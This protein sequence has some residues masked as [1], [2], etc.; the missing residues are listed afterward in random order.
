MNAATKKGGL[1]RGLD[2]LFVDN[3]TDS[4]AEQPADLYI[5]E[6]EPDRDQPRQDFDQEALSEL[7]ESIAQH[8]VI[9]PIIV[10]PLPGG[11]YRIVAGERRW[12]A[13]RLAGK[14]TIPAVVH[15]LTDLEAMTYALIENLQREDLNPVEEAEGYRRLVE[16][17]GL[18]QE[19]VAKLVGRSRSAVANAL[20]LLTLPEE[21]LKLLRDGQLTTGHAKAVLAV[22]DAARRGE[23]ARMVAEKGLTVREAERLSQKTVQQQ[24]ISLP[25]S[26]DPVIAEVELSLR[27]ALGV[28]VRVTC[29]NERGTLSID[30]YSKEQLYEFANRLGQ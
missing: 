8:G 17:S 11:G 29:R 18:T 26:R 23:I 16:T 22:T 30:F 21:A 25:E 20:R 5:S 10:R 6:I 12:R 4:G 14:N 27:D 13:S 19:Q 3:D 9:Q 15:N 7:A 2:A 24:K 1:G 28:E